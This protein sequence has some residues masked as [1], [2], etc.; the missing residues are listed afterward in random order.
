MNEKGQYYIKVVNETATIEEWYSDGII[1]DDFVK[2]IEVPDSGVYIVT[3]KRKVSGEYKELYGSPAT[4]EI[5][6]PEGPPLAFVFAEG[7]KFK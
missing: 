7:D 6:W 1:H 4:V 2:T 5:T 3:I